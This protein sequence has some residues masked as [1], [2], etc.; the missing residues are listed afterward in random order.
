MDLMDSIARGYQ[1]SPDLRLQWLQHMA[2]KHV[3][4][5]NVAEAAMCI[6]HA[7]ALVAEYLY[8]LERKSYMPVGCVAFQVGV[9]VVGVCGWWICWWD[10]VTTSIS[11]AVS[12]FDPTT[13][14]RILVI[15]LLYFIRKFLQTFWRRVQYQMT[16]FLLRKKGFAIPSSS[17]SMGS[18]D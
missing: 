12:S 3:Q 4:H 13:L 16:S 11:S 9:G 15:S 5:K 8:I 14:G 7:A 1:N 6:V 18:L 10:Y 17:L 2:E